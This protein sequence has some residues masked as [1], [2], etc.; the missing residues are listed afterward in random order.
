MCLIMEHGHVAGPVITFLVEHRSGLLRLVE[1]AAHQH[2]ALKPHFVARAVG[3]QLDIDARP[4]KADPDLVGLEVNG[5]AARHRLGH[6]VAGGHVDAVPSG[7]HRM[8][9]Q[10]IVD[11]LRQPRSAIEHQPHLREE[12]V[13]QDFVAIHRIDQ[14]GV[15]ERHVLK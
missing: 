14:H 5:A 10:A 13:A 12:G 1:I 3:Q 8:L 7:G 6:A 4:G 11:R 15:A 2:R 9:L